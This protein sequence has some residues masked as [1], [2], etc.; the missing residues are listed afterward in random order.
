MPHNLYRVGT[1]SSL[2]FEYYKVELVLTRLLSAGIQVNPLESFWF[3]EEVKY[4]GYKI[5]RE[6]IKPQAK[7]VEKMLAI[8]PPENQTELRGFIGMIN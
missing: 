8:A 5:S 3:Q 2:K 6:G 7:K 4:L 1:R